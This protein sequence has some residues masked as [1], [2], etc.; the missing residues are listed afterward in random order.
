VLKY[1]SLLAPG[2]IKVPHTFAVTCRLGSRAVLNDQYFALLYFIAGGILSTHAI[3]H[4]IDLKYFS[5]LVESFQLTLQH[6]GKSME[7]VS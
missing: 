5:V 3:A 1:H 7:P 6:L 4:L 2:T